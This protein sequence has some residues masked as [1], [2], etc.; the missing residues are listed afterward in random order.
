[1]AATAM[2]P[3]A[4][5]DRGTRVW[6]PLEFT[7]KNL[8]NEF[9]PLGKEQVDRL[10]NSYPARAEDLV[11][12]EPLGIREVFGWRLAEDLAQG[13][14]PALEDFSLLVEGLLYGL[15]STESYDLTTFN[16]DFRRPQ[17]QYL[18]VLR[19]QTAPDG[20]YTTAGS[21][22]PETL[23]CPAANWL[24]RAR[25]ED[26]VQEIRQRNGPRARG[27]L[28]AFLN[29]FPAPEMLWHKAMIWFIDKYPPDRDEGPDH[30]ANAGPFYLNLSP[31]PAPPVVAFFPQYFPGYLDLLVRCFAAETYATQNEVLL[32]KRQ[33][34][35]LAEMQLPLKNQNPKICGLGCMRVKSTN[36]AFLPNRRPDAADWERYWTA[37]QPVV[38]VYQGPLEKGDNRFSLPDGLRWPIYLWGAGGALQRLIPNHRWIYGDLA[39]GRNLHP[40]PDTIDENPGLHKTDDHCFY[41]T[42]LPNGSRGFHVEIYQRQVVGEFTALG[43][44]LWQ[45]FNGVVWQES[46][47]K[48]ERDGV[49]YLELLYGRLNTPSS[50]AIV[51][52]EPRRDILKWETFLAKAGQLANDDLFRLAAFAYG[53]KYGIA[54]ATAQDRGRCTEITIGGRKWW[55]SV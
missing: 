12:P 17:E 36:S 25:L 24:E 53:S 51:A 55:I 20:N 40:K 30:Q 14:G 38:N 29:R 15:L 18:V 44:A 28:R 19:H 43:F 37:V 27:L 34:H 2:T 9:T 22:S 48:A 21:L 5:P 23:V 50:V 32:L 8:K 54:R 6:L 47:G 39:H 42:G 52:P 7:G 10:A 13:H 49:T 41:V 31:S 1:M 33:D 16:L 46:S 35:L 4:N 3:V 11:C 45:I 26:R